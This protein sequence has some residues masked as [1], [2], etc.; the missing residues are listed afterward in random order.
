MNSFQVNSRNREKLISVKP[1]FFAIRVAPPCKTRPGRIRSL[2]RKAGF[3]RNRIGPIFAEGS[4]KK[5][6]LWNPLLVPPRPRAGLL[7]RAP[8]LLRD[9][10]GP[11][12]GTPSGDVYSF[13]IVLF[14]TLARAGPFGKT[15]LNPTDYVRALLSD[16][17]AEAPEQRPDF[18]AVRARLRP[19]RRG[20]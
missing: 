13:A 17:W 20:L 9:P 8:E 16:C 12:E 19:M 6:V 1:P 5:T 7:W 15:N 4:E 18:K 2:F 10:D 14:E 11:P 3:S